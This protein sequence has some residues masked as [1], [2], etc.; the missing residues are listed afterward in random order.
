MTYS[1]NNYII[2]KRQFGPSGVISPFQY[3]YLRD[4]IQSGAVADGLVMWLDSANTSSYSGSG[5]SWRDL[6]AN[7]YNGVL[8]NSP[9]FSSNIFTFNGSNQGV[10]FAINPGVSLA[11]NFTWEMWCKPTTT[12]SVTSQSTS[13]VAGASGQRYLIGATN[14]GASDGGAGVSIG[15]NGVTVVEHGNSYLPTTLVSATTIS[16]TVMSH[17]VI[18]YTSKQPRFYLNGVLTAT[19]LTS[20]RTNV[21]GHTATLGYGA[22]GYFAGDFP[23]FRAYNRSL[24]A[25]EITL[26]FNA[27][28]ARFGI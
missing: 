24:T 2:G 8:L 16:N 23:V 22:Y 26:N 12:R 13:G 27:Q 14:A 7:A 11:N 9:T 15:T 25:D 4:I 18:V 5:T 6:T 19:G 21:Y 3:A 28:R 10:D 1:R 20:P 17:I